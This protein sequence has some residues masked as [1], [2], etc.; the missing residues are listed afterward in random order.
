[1]YTLFPLEPEGF[2]G[3]EDPIFICPRLVLS[4]SGSTSILELDTFSN[5]ELDSASSSSKN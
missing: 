1:M 3:M 4:E 5:L 2:V